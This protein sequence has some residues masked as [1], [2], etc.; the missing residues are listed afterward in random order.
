[1]KTTID[2]TS[3]TKHEIPSF[4]ETDARQIK[5]KGWSFSYVYNFSEI[6]DIFLALKAHPFINLKEFTNYCEEINLPYEKTK[7]SKRRIL[8]HLNA[9][10][11]FEI[12]DSEYK[13]KGNIFANSVIGTPIS[14][15]DLNSFKEIYFT[16]FRFKEIF[17]WF[18]NPNVADRYSFIENL[19]EKAIIK[20]TLPLFVFSDKS[21]FT[22]SFFNKLEDNSEIFFIDQKNG[23]DL[24]RFW[25]VFIKWGLVLNV[26][27][28]F[29]LKNLEI[30]TITGK[31]I[32]CVYIL[33]DQIEDFNLLDFIKKKYKESYIYIPKLVLD[34]ALTYRIKLENVHNIIL[35]QYKIHK[36]HLSLERTSEIFVK[37]RVINK[38]DRIFFPKHNDSYVSHLIVR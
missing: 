35:E 9:L 14:L 26:I 36:E 31:G 12:I 19:K 28:K 8:E 4:D 10:K 30:K 3:S 20:N 7:W 23:E 6:R 33:N 1:M 29:N 2:L 38:G 13:A 21:R 15:Q 24:M 22:D 32:A 27:E 17:T 25:D 11:N 34:I 37:K 5:N 16:Y 18:I